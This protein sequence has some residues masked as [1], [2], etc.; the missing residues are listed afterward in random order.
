MR[1]RPRSTSTR[2][3]LIDS[4]HPSPLGSQRPRVL[5][6]PDYDTSFGP[7]AIELCRHVGLVLDEWQQFVLT[8]LLAV[9]AG[10]WA[11]FEAALEVARQNGKGGVYESREITGLFLL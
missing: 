11:A 4:P 9:R 5:W 7:E 3:L 6:I 1:R 10:K 2:T 8:V